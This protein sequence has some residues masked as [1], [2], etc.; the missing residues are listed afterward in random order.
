M[1]LTTQLAALSACLL[2]VSCGED[3]ELVRK[4]GE[5]EAEIA[6]LKG[7]LALAEERLKNL[8][9]DKTSELK[10]AESETRALQAEHTKL[11]QEVADLE[12]EHKSLRE[13]YEAYQR[14]YALR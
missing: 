12:A 11:T 13:E 3:P 14:K 8:P 4:H 7:E 6:K 9:E 1:N 10:A 5:Q 2:F